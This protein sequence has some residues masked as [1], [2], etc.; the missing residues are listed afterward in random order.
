MVVLFILLVVAA[1][2]LIVFE[3]KFFRRGVSVVAGSVLVVTIVAAF[4]L[5]QRNEERA[6]SYAMLLA[7]VPHE[8]RADFI[9]SK[10]CRACH[11]SHYASWH[12]TYHRTMTQ[13]ATPK[14]VVGEFDGRQLTLRGQVYRPKRKGE[15]FWVEMPDP[16]WLWQVQTRRGD[17]SGLQPP[18]QVERRVVMTT[19]SHHMQVFLG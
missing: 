12:R 18:R 4:F 19:G 13:L 17:T 2:S 1:A 6:A 9:S 14:A 3:A 7:A 10:T 16:R 8:G 5:N 15:E 11:P